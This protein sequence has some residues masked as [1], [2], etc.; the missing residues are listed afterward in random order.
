M[1]S[2]NI[3]FVALFEIDNYNVR[4]FASLQN[5]MFVNI[6]VNVSSN[7]PFSILV[8]NSSFFRSDVDDFCVSRGY[9]LEG[10]S[11]NYSSNFQCWH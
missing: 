3:H 6:F 11:Q 10:I 9:F 7:I 1:F 4:K 8:S 5:Q 2:V